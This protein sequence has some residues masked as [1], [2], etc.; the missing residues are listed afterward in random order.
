MTKITFFI[1]EGENRSPLKDVAVRVFKALE[2]DEWEE[3]E[4]ANYPPDDHYFAGYSKNATVTVCD[5]DDDRM[6]NYPFHIHVDD[7]RSHVGS[8][9]MEKDP[10]TIA[11]LLVSSGFTVFIPNG[12][13]GYQDWDGDGQIIQ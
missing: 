13:W 4:S 3:R 1:G 9:T 6:P 5:C 2:I 8:R 11:K 10:I 12:E 7:P